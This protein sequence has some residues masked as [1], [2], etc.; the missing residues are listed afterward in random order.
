[1]GESHYS[2]DEPSSDWTRDLIRRH[3]AH[4]G[5]G[6]P[7][8][9]KVLQVM[10]PDEDSPIDR[11]EAWGHFAFSN[12]LQKPMQ[13]VLE[14]VPADYWEEGRAAFF[15][16]LAITRPN[17]LVCFGKRLFENLPDVGRRIPLNLAP[18]GQGAPITDA[19]LYTY[20]T[21][22]GPNATVAAWVYHPSAPRRF[23]ILEAKRRQIGARMYYSNIIL[24]LNEGSLFPAS[25]E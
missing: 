4:E 23:N 15:G 24:A 9:T 17:V 20:D 18:N 3:A 2:D 21:E 8:L 7:F 19:W 16:Q 25:S 1:M 11:S 13:R 14:A 22:R 6:I 12:F 10:S 5:P